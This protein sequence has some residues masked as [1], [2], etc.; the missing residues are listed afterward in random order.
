MSEDYKMSKIKTALSLLVL[1]GL[2]ALLIGLTAEQTALAQQSA[3]TQ[4]L[5]NFREDYPLKEYRGK[6]YKDETV[7]I[8][9]NHFIDCTFENVIFRFDGEAP[10]RFT[11]DHFQGAFRLTS[12]NTVVKSTMILVGTFI[13]LENPAQ[14]QSPSNQKQNK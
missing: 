11:N 10:F 14:N 5:A 7:Q 6:R 12:N 13:K 8:D 4:S 3:N 9:G 1:I 2:L